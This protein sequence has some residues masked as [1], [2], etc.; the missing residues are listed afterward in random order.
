MR[1]K[2]FE[3][4]KDQI[5][6]CGIWCGSCI[7]GNGT[8]RE[9]TKRYED[10][11]RGYGIDDWGAKGFDPKEFMKGLSSLQNLHICVGCRK[12]GGNEECRIRPCASS[13]KIADCTEC[14]EPGTCKNSAALQK[15]R[16]GALAVG[17]V[18]KDRKCSQQQLIEKWTAEIRDKF[19]YCL[20]DI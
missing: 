3:S 6:Y 12:G 15:V 19:P 5:G 20:I 17:M 13:R 16:K 4:V 18:A 9:L 10:L 2:A 7:V 14:D 11:I 1:N 8:L